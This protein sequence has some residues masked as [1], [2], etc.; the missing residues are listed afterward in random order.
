MTIQTRMVG[1]VCVKR[2]LDTPWSVDSITPHAVLT[3]APDMDA[4]KSLGA[5]QAGELI[6]FGA[7]ELNFF[8]GETGDYRDNLVTG[9]PKLWVVLK[10]SGTGFA[11]SLVSAN[12]YE[13]EAAS[14]GSGTIVEALVMPASIAADLARFVEIHHVERAFVKRQ[15]ENGKGRGKGDRSAG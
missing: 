2:R 14:N 7:A 15:R 13:G 4:P 9:A 11:L 5:T 12:P 8:S 1:V 10:P 3:D 6:Y